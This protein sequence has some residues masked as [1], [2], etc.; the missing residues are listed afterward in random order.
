MRLDP[1]AEVAS[2]IDLKRLA[3]ALCAQ[4]TIFVPQDR[5]RSRRTF[6]MRISKPLIAT[7]LATA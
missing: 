2:Q 4:T 6:I 5:S 1:A 7:E 3:R